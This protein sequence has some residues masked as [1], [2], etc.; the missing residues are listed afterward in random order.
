MVLFKN[1]CHIKAESEDITI[2]IWADVCV[3]VI[4]STHFCL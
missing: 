4:P 3:A 2:L 1:V